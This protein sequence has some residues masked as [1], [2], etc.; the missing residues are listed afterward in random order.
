MTR[1]LPALLGVWLFCSISLADELRP[2]FPP[3][4]PAAIERITQSVFP[5]VVRLD[6]AQETFS[7]GK[8]T[9]RRGIGSGVIVDDL[10]HILTNFHVAGRGVEIFVTLANK[11]RVRGRL[12][13]DDH[14]TDLA[15]VQ[16]DLDEVRRKGIS[17][18]HAELGNSSTLVPGQ[19]VMAIGTP[20]GL[21]RTVTLGI[22]SNTDRT[23]Y[24][25]ESRIDEYETGLFANWI[26][27][28]TPI[29]Q[30][31]SGGPLV[32]MT[33][34]VVGINT[35]GIPGQNLN[36][37][38][39]IDVAKKVVGEILATA[40]EDRK[41]RVTR[42]WIGVD[43]KPLQDL[44]SF[45]DIDIN[46]GA[47]VSSVER[48]SPAFAA[49]IRPQDILLAINNV[50]LN[51]RFPE[52]IAPTRA[53]I[54]NLRIG[55]PVKVK[56]RRGGSEMEVDVT[57]EKLESRVGEERE[58]ARWGLSVREVTRTYANDARLDDDNGV[59]VTSVTDGF[60]AQRAE[61]QRGDIILKI[62]G[63]TC[64]DLDAFLAAYETIAEDDVPTILLE[65]RRGR[66]VRS[67][68]L[69]LKD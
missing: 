62:N 16:L 28:D 3:S 67:A 20:F 7:D 31:N 14:W 55:E 13:G 60:P 45:Y 12:V 9:L 35:R 18:S 48:N 57:P 15:V 40:G 4:S 61:L 10:G 50:P 32:D 54:S 8:R 59:L 34:K 38:I 27:M 2:F 42:A 33:G 24:P 47:L 23:F 53:M 11:E 41:G 17:F 19:D 52:E 1:L 21:A 30:G 37:A 6:V 58:L 43:F 5:A 66:G 68:I 26:Q 63:T 46:T 25:T 51:V 65:I 69:K 39:P 29:A 22:V 49:G 64:E 36:F 56:L 44:E